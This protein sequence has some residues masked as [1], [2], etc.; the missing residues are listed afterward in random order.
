M[1]GNLPTG[2]HLTSQRKMLCAIRLMREKS[3]FLGTHDRF[4]DGFAE[5]SLSYYKN[6][7]W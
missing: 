5:L 2:H 3:A 1:S 4:L 6:D 7:E